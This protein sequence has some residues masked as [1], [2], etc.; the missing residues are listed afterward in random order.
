[1]IDIDYFKHYN[2]YYGHIK[3]DQCLKKIS[4]LL[5]SSVEGTNGIACRYGGEEFALLLPNTSY[6]NGSALLKKLKVCLKE[7]RIQHNDSRISPF[8][9]ASFGIATACTNYQTL[10]AKK[11]V[12]FADACL[13]EAKEKGRD[14]IIGISV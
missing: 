6:E 11:L 8:V 9:T 12:I 4:Q 13:Y 14:K 2:D 5:Q 3:G 10:S 7:S 1:M